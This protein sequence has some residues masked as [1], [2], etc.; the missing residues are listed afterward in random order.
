V[1]GVLITS[2]WKSS[3]GPKFNYKL[4]WFERLLTHAA[5]LIAAGVP[6]VLAGRYSGL[7]GK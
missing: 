2:K 5:E 6:L 7:P 4:P 3:A 1:N